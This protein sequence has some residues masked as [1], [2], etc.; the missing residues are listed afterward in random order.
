M[1]LQPGIVAVAIYILVVFLSVAAKNSG[2]PHQ[3]YILTFADVLPLFCTHFIVWSAK[4][5]IQLYCM[6]S[7]MVA[8]AHILHLSG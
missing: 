4:S 3:K 6:A 5:S 7:L 8:A 1:D 2:N